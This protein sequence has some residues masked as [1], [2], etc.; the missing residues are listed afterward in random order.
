MNPAMSLAFWMLGK[1]EPMDALGYIVAQF[2]GAA[3]GVWL[4]A[5]ELL[6]T[7]DR[8][9]DR[10]CGKLNHSASNARLLKCNCIE[11]SRNHP[12]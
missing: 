8:G 5:V 11:R 2:A 9:R 12:S 6:R 10:L 7:L 4:A 3:I 1:L